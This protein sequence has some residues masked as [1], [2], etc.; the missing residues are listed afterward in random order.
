MAAQLLAVLLR[1]EAPLRPR[2]ALV[3]HAARGAQRARPTVVA[4]DGAREL[5]LP[6]G[7]EDGERGRHARHQ[8]QAALEAPLDPP[9]N[10]RQLVV[11]VEQPRRAAIAGRAPRLRG[12]APRAIR[13]VAARGE[14]TCAA[15][16]AVPRSRRPSGRSER[17][18]RIAARA[19]HVWAWAW[20]V[21]TQRER[22]VGARG[23]GRA[24]ATRWIASSSR[25]NGAAGAG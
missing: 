9:L 12:R 13:R 1:N 23:C 6:L 20:M 18:A 11:Q 10:S 17:R 3:V 7:A 4:A 21:G 25:A 14:R 15:A 19:K 5:Q 2:R 22:G 8:R 24:P 16:W